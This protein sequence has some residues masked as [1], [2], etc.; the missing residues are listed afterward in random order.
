MV[1]EYAGSMTCAASCA[2][3]VRTPSPPVG[4]RPPPKPPATPQKAAASP[5]TG[6]LP[7]ARYSAAASGGR[8]TYPASLAIEL[9]APRNT[10]TG[11]SRRAGVTNASCRISA[12]NR[13]NFSASPMP[14]MDTNTSGS[15]GIVAKLRS[16][17]E[18]MKYSPS[19]V[20][21]LRGS[22]AAPAATSETLTPS[23]PVTAPA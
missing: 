16:I 19:A 18:N 17:E 20:R 12:E 10:I 4:N 3:P 14:S 9:L 7:A 1:T 5:A 15:A 21:R 6:C 13:P 22:I 23:G 2:K 11:V 8:I